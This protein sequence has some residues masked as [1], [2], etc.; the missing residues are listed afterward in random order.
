[1]LTGRVAAGWLV[2]EWI[3][4]RTIRAALDEALDTPRAAAGADAEGT[5]PAG[6]EEHAP[7]LVELMRRIGR[8]IARL[9]AIDLIHGDLTTSNLM[10]REAEGAAAGESGGDGGGKAGERLAGSVALID[11]GL[12]TTSIAAEDKAVDLYVLE[13]A[14]AATHPRA[15]GKLFGEVLRAYGEGY[16]GGSGG[17]GKAVLRRLEDVRARGRKRS[18]LG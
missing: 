11:F 17:G 14:F 3:P 12:A 1:M 9:H 7:E 15:E 5:Q 13:R 18:M 4:G 10:L 2:T 6:D 16:V 8:A